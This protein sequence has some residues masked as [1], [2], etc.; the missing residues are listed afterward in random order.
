MFCSLSYILLTLSSYHFVY[1]TSLYFTLLYFT[2]P[3]CTSLSPDPY[4]SSY[5]SSSVVFRF[6]SH[7]ILSY[8]PFPS[9]VFYHSTLH[10]FFSYFSTSFF[11]F[12]HTFYRGVKVVDTTCPWVSKVWN[13]VDNHRKAGQTRWVHGLLC[14]C[15][16]FSVSDMLFFTLFEN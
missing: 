12:H 11:I 16:S 9:L 7:L 14:G 5:F 6:L 10:H 4:T 3:P 15:I 8:L 1:F 2:S 13:A